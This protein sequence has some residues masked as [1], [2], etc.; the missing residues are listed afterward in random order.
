MWSPE[1]VWTLRAGLQQDDEAAPPAGAGEVVAVE[2][3]VAGEVV[4]GRARVQAHQRLVVREDELGL[5]ARHPPRQAHGL[6]S[7]GPGHGHRGEKKVWEA[8]ERS[9]HS[10]HT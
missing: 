10:G 8:T 7:E 1:D 4:P 2:L 5:G 9:G 3:L 6:K